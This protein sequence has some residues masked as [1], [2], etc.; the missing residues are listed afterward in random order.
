MDGY[1]GK[2]VASRAASVAPPVRQSQD[3]RTRSWLSTTVEPETGTPLVQNVTMHN[4]ESTMVV[5]INVTEED[6]APL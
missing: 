5:N 3:A 4:P 2:D 1:L 6:K